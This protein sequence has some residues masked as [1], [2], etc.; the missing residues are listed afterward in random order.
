M[1]LWPTRHDARLSFI[2]VELHVCFAKC[3][4]RRLIYLGNHVVSGLHYAR[5]LMVCTKLHLQPQLEPWSHL[6]KANWMK[7]SHFKRGTSLSVSTLDNTAKVSECVQ[8]LWWKFCLQLPRMIL[9]VQR[10]ILQLHQQ[11]QIAELCTLVLTQFN[12]R[13]PLTKLVP[14]VALSPK[15]LPSFCIHIISIAWL[16]NLLLDVWYYD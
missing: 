3:V 15:F 6:D 5:V 1:L 10:I 12:S 14:N 4:V 11:R 2:C 13:P 9:R 7:S 16:Y 8:N